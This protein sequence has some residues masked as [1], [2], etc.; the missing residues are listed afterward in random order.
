MYTF[1]VKIL[2]KLKAYLLKTCEIPNYFH[3]SL[4]KGKVDFKESILKDL[5]VLLNITVI[6]IVI[7]HENPMQNWL[8]IQKPIP[9]LLYFLKFVNIQGFCKNQAKY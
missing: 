8:P 1:W 4:Q 3:D 7:F 2:C 5:V 6:T 9:V